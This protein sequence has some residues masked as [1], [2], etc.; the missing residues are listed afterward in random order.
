M[1]KLLIALVLFAFTGCSEGH[2]FPGFDS[3]KSWEVKKVTSKWKTGPE[4]RETSSGTHS[5]RWTIKTGIETE[6]MNGHKFA[7]TYRRRDI[8]N[9]GGGN[10]NGVWLE[11]SFSIW[12]RN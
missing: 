3:D 12:E 6:L 8:N 11:C 5:E 9:G 2:F 10:D 7:I 1:K 4:F